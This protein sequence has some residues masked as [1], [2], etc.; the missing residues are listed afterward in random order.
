MFLRV[1]THYANTVSYPE[2]GAS[3]VLY[4]G[5]DVTFGRLCLGAELSIGVLV[6]YKWYRRSK[7]ILVRLTVE[8]AGQ[9]IALCV[10]VSE[11]SFR[12]AAHARARPSASWTVGGSAELETVARPKTRIRVFSWLLWLLSGTQMALA[13]FLLLPPEL[14]RVEFHTATVAK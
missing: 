11:D 3:G 2:L 13:P 6:I 4:A 10:R 1:S 14:A 8:R 9:E 12:T 5:R 7:D